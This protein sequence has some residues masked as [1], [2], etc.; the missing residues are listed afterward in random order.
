[1]TFM[2]RATFSAVALAVMSCWPGETALAACNATVNGRPMSPQEC[3]MT[4][5][6]YGQVIPGNYLVDDNGNWVN[7]NNPR[8]RGN[9][10]RD[11]Q[12]TSSGSRGS[13]Y[14]QSSPSGSWGSGSYVS[15]RGVYD[16]TGGCE[17][18]S[19]VNIID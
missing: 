6:V 18:G 15:P 16:S 13:R 4:I 7:I 2:K 5:Q 19:C 8:H 10:Y 9:I 11:A 17:G 3:A 12:N 14:Y 1:M